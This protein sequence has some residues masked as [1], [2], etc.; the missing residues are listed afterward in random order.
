[1]S[2]RT[3]TITV[4]ALGAEEYN[5]FGYNPGDMIIWDTGI[6]GSP[7]AIFYIRARTGN[8]ITAELQNGFTAA[9]VATFTINT[10]GNLYFFNCRYFMLPYFTNGTF[11]AASPTVTNVQA[12]NGVFYSTDLAVDDAFIVETGS[13]VF[14]ILVASASR[15]T[16]FDTGAKTITLSGNTSTTT[17]GRLPLIIK[18]APANS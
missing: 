4:S 1:M 16:A 10:T 8:V 18:K 6:G 2:N 7:R 13:F 14:N 15:I 17:S 12:P 3:A 11:T 5:V 9:N